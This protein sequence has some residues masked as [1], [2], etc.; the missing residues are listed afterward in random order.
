[1]SDGLG[2]FFVNLTRQRI[3]DAIAKMDAIGVVHFAPVLRAIR[4]GQIVC[5]VIKRTAGEEAMS[6]RHIANHPLPALIIMA[7]DDHASSGPARF[8]AARKALRYARAHM[9]HAAGGQPSDYALA[10]Q[11]AM[12]Q[13]SCCL[14][15]TD[16]AHLDEWARF[17]AR[18]ALPRRVPTLLV[19]PTDGVH[20]I[21]NGAVH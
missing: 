9:I 15:E 6:L 7:D 11:A 19:R 12:A 21:I 3:N 17:A 4:D 10:I 1:M 2:G 13:R 16:A 5:V 14:V 8:P 20:P 18:A